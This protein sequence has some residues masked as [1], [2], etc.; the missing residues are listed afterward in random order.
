MTTGLIN[1][2]ILYDAPA[3]K[4][5]N[6]KRREETTMAEKMNNIFEGRTIAIA[7]KLKHFSRS[8]IGIPIV[9][10]VGTVVSSVTKA[11]DHLTCGTRGGSKF[12]N[13]RELGVTVLTEQQFSDMLYV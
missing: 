5:G 11:T 8:H 12:A 4:R 3:E 2:N 6:M 9:D 1:T 10:L 7:G 13:A